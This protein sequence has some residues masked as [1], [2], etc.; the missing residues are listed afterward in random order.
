M[1]IYENPTRLSWPP[2]ARADRGARAAA[3]PHD[4]GSCPVWH[5]EIRLGLADDRL[6]QQSLE[7]LLVAHLDSRNNELV[8][9][10]TRVM[11]QALYTSSL[12]Q[13]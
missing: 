8:L 4:R 10:V 11:Q 9:Q 13:E 3:D 12:L 1:L 5:A 7:K 2:E 6:W